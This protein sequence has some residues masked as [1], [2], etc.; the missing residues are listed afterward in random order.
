MFLVAILHVYATLKRQ[1]IQ[2]FINM[3]TVNTLHITS[4]NLMFL[5]YLHKYK[6][7]I[8]FKTIKYHVT[9]RNG[10]KKTHKRRCFK[11]SNPNTLNIIFPVS[12][13]VVRV[14]MNDLPERVKVETE[15]G[16]Y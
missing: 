10:A 13:L 12:H 8:R 1:F 14:Q 15:V 5:H 3:S 6:H 11:N 2:D 7:A 4:K 16:R 9:N